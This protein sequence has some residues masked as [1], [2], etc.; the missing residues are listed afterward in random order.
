MQEN[1]GRMGLSDYPACT[2][3]FIEEEKGL[4]LVIQL[5]L[6]KSGQGFTHTDHFPPHHAPHNPLINPK[7]KGLRRHSSTDM[8]RSRR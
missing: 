5:N 1:F 2:P 7:Y 8:W 3:L 6:T 4:P